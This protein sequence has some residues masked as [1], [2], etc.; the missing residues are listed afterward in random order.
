MSLPKLFACNRAARCHGRRLS[1]S[2]AHGKG[3]RDVQNGGGVDRKPSQTFRVYS[4]SQVPRRT[5]VVVDDLLGWGGDARQEERERKHVPS[6][7][8]TG[9]ST[10]G[11]VHLPE[12]KSDLALALKIDDLGLLHLVVQIV[13]LAGPLT[14]TGE[15]GETTVSLGDVVLHTTLAV[16]SSHY[17]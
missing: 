15:D 13:A 14:D 2:H 10:W 1:R 5:T 9:T 17:Y 16:V 8:N 3:N 11:L 6:Q 7:R 4:S 12:D